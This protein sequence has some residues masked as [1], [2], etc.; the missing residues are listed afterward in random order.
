MRVVIMAVG[1]PTKHW[2]GLFEALARKPDLELVIQVADVSAE[3]EQQLRRLAAEQPHLDFRLAPHLLRGED[4]TGHMASAVFRPGSLRGL[5]D[6][7]P[8][9]VHVIGEPAYLSTFQV[10][11]ARNRFWPHV[12]ISQYAAQ[13]VVT[14]FPWPFPLLERYAYRQIALAL[15]ITPAALRVLRT[16][17]YRGPAE[18]VPL[19]VD[20]GAF[21]PR[22]APPTGP[23]T[24]GFVGRLEPHKG[25][26][27]LVA[28][29]DRLGCRLLLVGDGSLRPWLEEQAA[30]RPGAVE[31]LPWTD[32]SAIPAVMARMHVLALPSVEVVRRTV[33]PWIRV[34]LREQFGRVLVE[35]MSLG[36]PVVATSAGE[37]PY[38]LGS[39][40]VIVPQRDPVAL[41][42]A[43]ADLRDHPGNA[44]EFARLGLARA[45]CF[46]WE[47]VADQHNEA[48]RGLSSSTSQPSRQAIGANPPRIGNA[49]RLLA[50]CE[51]CGAPVAAE[52]PAR[53][54]KDG[55]DI[56][57][58]PSC[59]LLSRR[60]LPAPSELEEIYGPNYFKR[61]PGGRWQHGYSDYGGD[62]EI[63][64]LDA[65]RRLA[66]ISSHLATGRLLDVGCASGY[67]LDEAR[68][69]GWA[70]EGVD[71]A[72][73][74]IAI[75]RERFGLDARAAD[76][77]AVEVS[78]PSLDCVTMWDYIEH[79]REPA[80]DLRKAFSS[81]RPGGILAL[82]TG[83]AAAAFARLSG[84]RWHL[85][86]PRH[87]N[88]FF[89]RTHL[90]R[91][92][93]S[94]GFEVLEA[95]YLPR[96]ATLRSLS[97]K[98]AA[99]APRSRVVQSAEE[100]LG[101]SSLGLATVTVNTFDV[102]TI[103]ARRTLAAFPA[104]RA[105]TP[106]LADDTALAAGAADP[107][108]C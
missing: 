102:V 43:F 60:E 72:R 101:R 80:A 107:E 26:A 3:T 64:R 108:S 53:W 45:A 25:I 74:M 16:K 28:A 29:C 71:V 18:L 6:S 49:A 75:A 39:A 15:P 10:I 89:T 90:T 65:R 68:A 81:L 67:F 42:G 96:H 52:R 46:D 20:R 11:R 54:V 61:P 31:L 14:R 37:I 2:Q 97:Y 32:R 56:V 106:Q 84:S 48:W 13:N 22:A 55:F 36:V 47:R 91:M 92:L 99:L 70:V 100:W 86:T 79:S 85:L 58:C 34:P 7:A 33:A 24:V 82:S 63:R 38:V 76:F 35:A 87:H 41:A 1:K 27:D 69:G 50:R 104:P 9:V 4:V 44:E 98:L 17:G 19:G 95:R 105:E 66:L 8:D 62:E 59:G 93:E 5:R 103:V 51:L 21:A 73:A 78:A 94:T 57:S 83:D 88:F 12:P 77:Q 30:R 23:F 40:G